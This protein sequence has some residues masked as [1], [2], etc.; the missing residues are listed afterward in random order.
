MKLEWRTS[1]DLKP[2]FPLTII[3]YCQNKTLDIGFG[4][5]S[6][7]FHGE[8]LMSYVD[9]KTGHKVLN[10]QLAAVYERQAVVEGAVKAARKVA[11]RGNGAE[12]MDDKLALQSNRAQA[13][14]RK[15]GFVNDGAI[16]GA[17]RP[18]FMVAEEEAAE[19]VSTK[20]FASLGL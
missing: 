9:R 19:V 13:Q 20:N 7:T 11:G 2:S 10:G 6:I 16:A 3:I 4:P 1:L 17:L 18:T 12:T 14:A 5:N 15:A 8:V